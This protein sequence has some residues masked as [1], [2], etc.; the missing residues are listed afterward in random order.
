MGVKATEPMLRVPRRVL[1]Q[2]GIPVINVQRGG[3]V[4]LHSPGQIVGYP[5][6]AIDLKDLDKHLTGMEDIMLKVLHSYNVNAI[7]SYEVDTDKKKR[8]PGAWI[9]HNKK[10]CKLGSIGVEMRNGVTMH[11]FALNVNN[12]IALFDLIDMCGFKNKY[13]SSMAKILDRPIAMPELKQRLM[14]AFAETFGY[15]VE[16]KSFLSLR[17]AVNKVYDTR[18]KEKE[19]FSE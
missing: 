12:D 16:Q 3:K 6:R 19:Q 14:G 9:V 1:N 13:A 17:D 10:E 2:R 4:T 11:G 5:I 18:I 8:L 15:S 7:K